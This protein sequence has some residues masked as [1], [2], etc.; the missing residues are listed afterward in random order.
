M[1]A[2]LEDDTPADA[3]AGV[4]GPDHGED[5]KASDEAITFMS[6]IGELTCFLSSLAY[7]VKDRHCVCL[8]IS[9]TW[10]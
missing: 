4:E 6:S 5:L 9:T 7:R 8:R 1:Q 10:F 3:L 2:P